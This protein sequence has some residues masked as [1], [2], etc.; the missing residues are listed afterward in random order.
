MNWTRRQDNLEKV[1]R[2]YNPENDIIPG[3]IRVTHTDY[4]I[5][6]AV[7]ELYERIERLE[8]ESTDG[9]AEEDGG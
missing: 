2:R 8:K 4:T 9:R 7:R 5:I 3:V 6:E 1:A